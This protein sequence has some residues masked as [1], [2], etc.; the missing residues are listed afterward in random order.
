MELTKRIDDLKDG[1]PVAVLNFFCNR[2]FSGV[3]VEEEQIRE[4]VP[5]EISELD[6]FHRLMDHFDRERSVE[7]PPTDSSSVAKETL[8]ACAKSESLSPVLEKA[9]EEYSDH[10]F[11]AE[12][13]LS[14]GAAVMLILAVSSTE[15]EGT[16]W[17][18][19]ISKSQTSA[20]QIR[21]V[22]EPVCEMISNILDRSE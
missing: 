19:K 16:L 7:L 8:K 3:T 20:E 15:I 21:A 5:I 13:I 12:A 22:V 2:L 6:S 18:M 4:G 17:G 11:G 10:L 9:L 14:I 1:Q